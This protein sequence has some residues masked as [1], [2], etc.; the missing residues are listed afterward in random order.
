MHKEDPLE[1]KPEAP[2]AAQVEPE[3]PDDTEA[4]HD[5]EVLVAD[6]AEE[7]GVQVAA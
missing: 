7:E 6:G 4:K 1:V 3:A 2:E 5:A